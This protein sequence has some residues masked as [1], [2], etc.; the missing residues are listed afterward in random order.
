MRQDVKLREGTE[1]CHSELYQNWLVTSGEE[2]CTGVGTGDSGLS[3]GVT[4]LSGHQAICTLH[5][6]EFCAAAETGI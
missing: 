5:L 2:K 6:S 4:H 3:P 1:S